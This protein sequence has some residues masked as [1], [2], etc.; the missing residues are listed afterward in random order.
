MQR[1]SPDP[2]VQTRAAQPRDLAQLLEMIAQ[3]A[4]HHGDA[5]RL[6]A[7]QLADDLFGAPPWISAIV[8]ETGGRL[9]GYTVL[10]PLI[11]LHFGARGMDMHHLFVARPYRHRGVGR[12][13]V[14]A[15]LRLAR[16]RG[17][18][19]MTVSTDP[20][21]HAA[22]VFYIKAGFERHAATAPRF[23]RRL[24]DARD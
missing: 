13:L 4:A 3:L 1:P 5:A 24:A 21:N 22:Q 15:A 16:A 8:A 12:A 7:A 17:C 19:Y 6:S 2:Q 18:K 20:Q 14:C 9:C 10:C 23:R 11:Q